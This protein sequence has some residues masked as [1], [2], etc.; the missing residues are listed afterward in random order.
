MGLFTPLFWLLSLLLSLLLLLKKKTSQANKPT[1][2]PPSS[3]KLPIIGNL[4]QLGALPHRSLCN[5][6][7]KYGPV[8]LLHLG[9]IPVVLISSAEA[10]REVLKVHDI[11]SCSRPPIAGAG[12]LTY[13]YSDVVFT[14]YGEYWREIRK[15]CVLELFS[16]KRVKSFRFVREEEVASLMDS[17]SQS[18]SFGSPV[19]VTELVFSLTGSII[20]RTAF[21]R[22]SQGN[23]FDRTKL[24]E[25]V[26]AAETVLGTFSAEEYFPNFGWIWDMINGHNKEVERVFHELDTF[27]ERVIQDHLQSGREKLQEDIIDV[28]LGIEK[29][30][31]DQDGR[32]WLTKA[33]IKAVL[34][35]MF[36]AGVDT[37]A[38]TVNWAMA[39]LFRQPKLMKKAQNEV[40]S[41]VG[42][43]GRVT[44]CDLDQLDYLKMVVK[45]TLR[46]HPPAP[47]LIPRE[48]MSYFKINEY[49][50]HPKT[51]IIIN[52]WAIARDPLY[53]ENPEEFCPERFVDNSVDFKG[54]NFEFLP[55]G[56]G[57][58]GCP[59]MHMGT[60]TSELLLANLLYS[61]DWKLPGGTRE[62]EIDMEE[63]GGHSL[64]LSKKIPLLLV[65]IKY[66]PD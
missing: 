56:G 23:D 14:P 55:F 62:A 47:L 45:E 43:K 46:L 49:D 37:S 36:L 66:L 54:N 35:N 22:C 58:R 21:G 64:T 24:Y 12:R 57:R 41:I 38:L 33:H 5:L 4:H 39:E 59:G 48:T 9:R 20:F 3:P 30:Q 27:F 50:I 2:L 28:M 40:R 60:V 15:I 19:N 10:A 44:E 51:R 29:E 42:N 18:S 16:V 11:A 65:P 26:H 32:A 13:N 52:A 1:R 25:I 6:S 7:R 34:L 8:L 17:I 53:W 31:V 61:F 63:L